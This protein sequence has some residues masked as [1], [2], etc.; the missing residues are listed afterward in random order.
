MTEEPDNEFALRRSLLF[1]PGAEPRKLEKAASAGADVLILDLEDAVSI[2]AKERAR[3]N[4]ARFLGDGDVGGAEPVVR[5]NPPG[6]SWFDEDVR[7]S[8]EAGA[9]ALMVPKAESAEGMR[10]VAA[11][12]DRYESPERSASTGLIPLIETAAGLLAA[13]E[14]GGCSDRVGAMCF[15]HVDFSRDMQLPGA[16]APIEMLLHA[17]SSFAVA[18]RAA[19]VDPIDTVFVDVRDEAGFRADAALGR[20]LGFVG[21]LC[22]HPGQ[23]PLANEV[24]TPAPSEVDFAR[25][26]LE[27]DQQAKV[28]GRGVFTVDGKMIDAPIL[29]AQRALL[30]RARRSGMARTPEE[31]A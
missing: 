28:D 12:V 4:V 19:R 11:L 14:I 29:E 5:V 3:E 17:R 1:V 6:T 20:R 2:D 22:I 16:D 7:A 8:V 27:A 26:V 13:A 24:H 18:A 15:G 30:A 25:R 9:A 21:K 10:A 23:V 31:D